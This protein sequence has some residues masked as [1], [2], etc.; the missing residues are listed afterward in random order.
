MKKKVNMK[1]VSICRILFILLCLLIGVAGCNQAGRFQ[2]VA[3]GSNPF[4]LDTV[5]GQAWAES[6]GVFRSSKPGLSLPSLTGRFQ[7]GSNDSGNYIIDT[8]TG[9]VWGFTSGVF[10]LRK[11]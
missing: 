4:V 3:N 2:L 1:T 5:T 10:S 8:A 7:G 9:E 6:S 11:K